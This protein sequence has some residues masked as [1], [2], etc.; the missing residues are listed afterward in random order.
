MCCSLSSMPIKYLFSK[1][2]LILKIRKKKFH[3]LLLV[4][5]VFLKY[6]CNAITS[7][8]FP[9]EQSSNERAILGVR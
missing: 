6:S 3:F 5:F 8:L 7:Y 9:D 4:G 1:V 2:Y